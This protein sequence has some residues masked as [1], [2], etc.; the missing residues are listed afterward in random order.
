MIDEK[1]FEAARQAWLESASDYTR[2]DDSIRAAIRAYE[3]AKPAPAGA[4]AVKALEWTDP[5]PPDGV[6]CFYDHVRADTV[7]GRL[8]IEWKSW[9][10]YDP[11]AVYFRAALV[12]PDGEG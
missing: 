1:A 4:V 8:Q 5:A 6:D 11:P 9:K 10:D 7:F 3:A 2:L 12:S